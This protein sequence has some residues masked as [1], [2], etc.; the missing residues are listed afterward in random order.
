M[1]V[2][3]VSRDVDFEVYSQAPNKALMIMPVPSLGPSKLG[4]N[5]RSGWV[6]TAAGIRAIKGVELAALQRDADFYGPVTLR[7]NFAKVSLLGK[8]NIGYREV[9]VLHLQPT[10]GASERLYLEAETYLPARV[11][12]TRM[13]GRLE[14]PVEIYLDDWRQVDGIMLPFRI[15]QSMP[16]LTLVFSVKEIQHNVPL[17]AQMFDVPAK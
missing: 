2:V 16:R 6:Q 9:Y 13:V 10:S 14:A 11:N 4:F 1:D 17:N 12:T 8:S 5:G 3:G 15:S 7:T